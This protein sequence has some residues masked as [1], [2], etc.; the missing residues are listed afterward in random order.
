MKLY[1]QLLWETQSSAIF[2]VLF[3]HCLSR[4]PIWDRTILLRQEVETSIL[5]IHLSNE[6]KCF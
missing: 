3:M 4:A 5:L 2:Y 6:K 1:L